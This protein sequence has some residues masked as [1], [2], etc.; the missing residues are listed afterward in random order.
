MEERVWGFG[1]V[2]VGRAFY[3]GSKG[4]CSNRGRQQ[5]E[6]RSSGRRAAA[7]LRPLAKRL[8]PQ[9]RASTS[10]QAGRVRACS[11]A[12]GWSWDVGCGLQREAALG[13]S[14]R[15]A[16]GGAAAAETPRLPERLPRISARLPV[17]G[18][19]FLGGRRAA[20]RP[21]AGQHVAAALV[22]EEDKNGQDPEG[23]QTPSQAAELAWRAL[24]ARSACGGAA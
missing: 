2:R 11:Q 22:H 23:R 16:G 19:Q 21:T 7:Q 17:T 12:L 9:P 14:S 8:A 4:Y 6:L 20:R 10:G 3:G 15:P 5:G 13:A 1:A 18:L 24:P